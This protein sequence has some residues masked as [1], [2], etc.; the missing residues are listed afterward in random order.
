M[1][2]FAAVLA[3]QAQPVPKAFHS[4]SGQFIVSST[5]P[6]PIGNAT[7]Q[8]NRDFVRLDST[9]LP[10][11]CER[12]KG[13]LWRDLGMTEPYRGKIFLTLYP[14]RSPEDTILIA[15]GEFRDGWQ[16]RVALPDVL[17]HSK[18]VDGI[19]QAL[20]LEIANRGAA[21]HGAE[22]PL[23]LTEGFSERILNSSEAEVIL[24]PPSAA[25]GTLRG[26]A[27]A[28]L[29]VDRR[30]N[31]LQQVH[32][33]LAGAPLLSFQQLSWPSPDELAGSTGQV[34]RATAHFFVNQLL[35]L[36][37]GR[38]CLRATVTELARYYN[39]Q[40]A[41][42]HGFQEHFRR[43]VEV[44]KWWTLQLMHFTGRELTQ[45]W[46]A[47][48]S[49]KKLDEVIRS[50]VQVRLSTNELPLHTEVKVQTIIDKWPPA[51]QTEALQA[52]L[53]QLELLRVRLAKDLVPLLDQYHDTIQQ[54]L[55]QRDQG[56][57]FN[58]QAARQ[59]LTAE[60]LR[61]LNALDQRRAQLQPETP[62]S[63]PVEAALRVISQR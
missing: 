49:W 51:R 9:I 5:P 40:F 16:Y 12:I 45:T 29:T 53:R 47:D 30:E 27:A 10:V 21:D 17:D 1:L 43:P 25:R 39:W 59:R 62:L 50:D 48:E 56:H 37:N 38:A 24:P 26:P 61:R 11:S 19:V 41:F 36:P 35:N 13:I 18:F 58:K 34:Y 3:L 4:R 6:A 31:P 20:L 63:E 55:Q 46:P 42:L 15:S 33:Q 7:L 28:F 14:A 44:E 8:T 60:T 57:L 54:Y 2:L 22:I 32:Q 52:K 23:W